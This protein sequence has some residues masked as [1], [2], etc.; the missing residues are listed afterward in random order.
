MSVYEQVLAIART[1]AAAAA[2]GDLNTAV[3]LLRERGELIAGAP[4]AEAS[5]QPLIRAIL[6][7][8]RD[9]ATAIRRRMIAI[10]DEALA[11]RQGQH[12]LAGYGGTAQRRRDPRLVDS[13]G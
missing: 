5:D 12:A 10:R 2:G 11:L 6:E 13:V 3:A 4:P 8:D 1:Q 9:I 7:L